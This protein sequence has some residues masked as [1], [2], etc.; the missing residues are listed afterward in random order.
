MYLSENKLIVLFL[1]F[2]SSVFS[3]ESILDTCNY[4]FIKYSQNIIN[5]DEIGLSYFFTKLH[6]MEETNISR[7]S[8][9]HLGDSHVAG[10]SFPNRLEYNF[11]INFGKL[12]RTVYN[13]PN[14]VKKSKKRSHKKR[15]KGSDELGSDF[16]L[17]NS[18]NTSSFFNSNDSSFAFDSLVVDTD[19]TWFHKIPIQKRGVFY[20][21]YGNVGKSFVYFVNSAEVINQL[22]ESKPDLVIIT[23]GTNDAFGVNF[24]SSQTAFQITRLIQKI[25]SVNSNTSI[26][27]TIPAESFTKHNGPNSNILVMRNIINT[28]CIKNKVCYW[29]FYNIMGS[30]NLM[31]VWLENGLAYKDKIHFTKQGYQLIADLFYVAIMKS[32]VNFLI[33]N[34]TNFR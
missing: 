23:L 31:D 9:Y 16:Y 29:D 1:F 5:N 24:D 4:K 2:F 7:V 18:E 25:R 34:Q 8:I 26:I 3:Q 32:Y 21:I 17:Y 10:L 33:N 22:K 27:I 28:V 13:H 6:Q 14:P 11:Q 15:R 19:T 12:G 20:S 30:G